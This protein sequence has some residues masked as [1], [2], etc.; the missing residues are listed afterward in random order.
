MIN[1]DIL[2]QVILKIA[3]SGKIRKGFDDLPNFL[4]IWK[5]LSFD[6]IIS[7]IV[8]IKYYLLYSE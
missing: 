6:A 1:C 2:L 4:I 3:Q 5:S 7:F 8:L